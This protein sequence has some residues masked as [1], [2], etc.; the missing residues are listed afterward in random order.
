MKTD[1]I[2]APVKTSLATLESEAA[3]AEKMAADHRSKIAAE[4]IRIAERRRPAELLMVRRDQ[5][6]ESIGH[7][8]NQFERFRAEDERFEATLWPYI[9]RAGISSELNHLAQVDPNAA[10]AKRIAEIIAKRIVTI[11]AELKLAD[12]EFRSEAQKNAPDL[13]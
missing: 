5:I 4:Q 7:A 8:R 9:G 1:T 6:A 11:E 13:L 2:A 10:N 12:A 3:A